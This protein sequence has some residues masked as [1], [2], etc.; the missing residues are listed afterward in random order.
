MYLEDFADPVS[1]FIALAHSTPE[2]PV[3]TWVDE[4][5]QDA[6][7]VSFERL[8]SEAGAIAG[9]LGGR[10]GLV[11]G[12][13]VLIIMQ[14]GLDFV[15][16]YC[17]CLLGRFIP[18]PAHPY[19]GPELGRLQRIAANAGVRAMLTD[20]TLLRAYGGSPAGGS[21]WPAAEWYDAATLVAE[22]APAPEWKA[23]RASDLA[24]L[25][26][27]S[28]STSE[29]KGVRITHG[30]LAHQLECNRLELGLGPHR[31]LVLWV[32]QYHDLGLISGLTSAMVGNG[33]LYQMSPLSFLKR[34]SVWLEVASRVRATH[35]AAPNFAYGLLLRRT[36]PEEI[37]RLSLG[38]VQG[39]M[40]AAEP[41]SP[42]LMKA[43]F[44]AFSAAGLRR[45]A[46]CAAYGLA[47]HTVGV[48]VFGR[49][50]LL[51]D[52]ESFERR[53]VTIASADQGVAIHS[54]GRPSAGV[55]AR[56]V[57][58]D[59]L[60][61]LGEDR[62]GEIWVDSPSK[63]DGYY[64]MPELTAEVFHARTRDE[65]DTHEYL[66]TGDLGFLH[67]GELFVTGRLKDLMIFRGRN[68][69]PSDIELT[70]ETS[71]PAI[72]P[73]CVVA[74]SVP[75][76]SGEEA[77]VVVA[78]VGDPPSAS[79]HD[80]IL[81]A[82]ARA[83]SR[84]HGQ[85]CS[86]VVLVR[87]QTVPKTMSGKLRRRDSRQAFLN[88]EFTRSPALVRMSPTAPAMP[89][90]IPGLD[91][92]DDSLRR[93]FARFVNVLGSRDHSHD[94]PVPAI[95][96]RGTL[97]M[98]DSGDI[99]RHRFF[100]RAASY[101][102]LLRHSNTNRDPDDAV[103]TGRGAAI[104][105][106][107]PD[108]PDDLHRTLLDVITM[109]GRRGLVRDAAS[110]TRWFVG[111]AKAREQLDRTHESIKAYFVDF[112]RSPGS[113]T[114]MHY[115]SQSAFHYVAVDGSR[116]FIRYRIAEATKA[117]DAGR[118]PI[119]PATPYLEGHL[120]R[121]AGDDRPAD[122]LRQDFAR[123]LAGGPVRYRLA[124]QLR[125]EPEGE[126]SRDDL[127]DATVEWDSPWIDVADL[128]LDTVVTPEDA[129][130]LAFSVGNAPRD[131]A[132]VLARNAH[133]PAS[134]AHLRA[135][136][137][138]L[139]GRLRRREPL[140]PAWAELIWK[141]PASK[142]DGRK[143]RVCVLGGGPSGLT[144]ART[145]ESLGHAVT[146]FER[147]AEV[148]GMAS[149]IMLDGQP[150]DLGAHLCTGSYET[151]ADLARDLGVET[152][153]T[154]GYF[155]YELKSRTVIAQDHSIFLRD[156]YE[157]YQTSRQSF[158]QIDRP[159]LAHSAAALNA[160]VSEW[161]EAHGLGA[162]A[163]SMGPN[164]TAA[165]YGYLDDPDLSAVYL[166]KFSEMI[167]ALSPRRRLSESW[168]FTIRNGFQTLWKAVQA[169]LRDVRCA[170][171]VDSVQRNDGKVIV[172][173]G[174]E[175]WTFDDL[176]V[177]IPPRDA[178]A[179]LDVDPEERELLES[180]RTFDYVTTVVRAAD[181]PQLGLYLLKENCDSLHRTGHSVAYH[182]R[183]VGS[184][185]F[186][187]YAYGDGK[188]DEDLDRALA[189]DIAAMGGTLKSIV[190]RRR[191]SYMPHPCAAD[192]R[193]GFFA[194]ME[195]RQGTRNTYYTGSL[196]GFELVEC[197]ASHART[198]VRSHF[199]GGTQS[200]AEKASTTPAVDG[201]TTIA[202]VENWLAHEL[203]AELD[204]KEPIPRDADLAS[205]GIDS[206]TAAA[207]LGNL[208]QW[209]GWAVPPYMIFD[210]PTIASIAQ[211]VA[212]A[213][214]AAEKTA[215]PSST[216][217]I[218]LNAPDTS[219]PAFLVGGL[220]GAALYLRELAESFPTHQPVFALQAAG[221]DGKEPPFATVAAAADAYLS[222]IRN[223]RPRGP[224]R[225]AGHS[226][227]GLVAYEMACRL[228]E[229]GEAVR[230]VL[231]DTMLFDEGDP[232]ELPDEDLAVAEL[233]IAIRIQQRPDI[234]PDSA[235]ISQLPPAVMREEVLSAIAGSRPFAG[236]VTLNRWLPTYRAHSAAMHDFRPQPVP[237]LRWRLLKAEAGYP[238]ALMHPKRVR[239]DCYA[240]PLLGWEG[241]CAPSAITTVPGNH[242]TMI[243]GRN[244]LPTARAMLQ[245]FDD[246]DGLS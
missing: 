56:I 71:H 210:Q 134:I 68:V 243:L 61:A 46:F 13:R 242:Y 185:V 230:L 154:T 160:P 113:F 21:E 178:L 133:D 54:C 208:T 33:H 92:F 213:G 23:P 184:D 175:E 102:V 80:D 67:E 226:F 95:T 196:L 75:D 26:Y 212:G 4:N 195:G 108:K 123:R 112:W 202:S 7:T 96:A 88:G 241:P 211:L 8:S 148:G 43:F 79:E 181:L 246:Q 218:A 62:V 87:P 166:L 2:A 146:L 143:R 157:Q 90:A 188:S 104:R 126:N 153:P 244:A 45:E 219:P 57:D 101:P 17:G 121:V 120:A 227:G 91:T 29:P 158:P 74:F 128:T 100:S 55:H 69:Y 51:L 73:R 197:A 66:R 233:L 86:A 111:D 63:A 99:P 34:P 193:A 138:D 236:E 170:A 156:A 25:Q 114:E 141:E 65:S 130:P 49:R 240:K 16:A 172:K 192:I 199:G 118:V 145:L 200:A 106:L 177:A 58:P 169:D 209:L 217:L 231:L 40:S 31:S 207:I 78:E 216:R 179:V 144:A 93:L 35:L 223:V 9:V 165:G 85:P 235:A 171:S 225:L 201:R 168:T 176:V 82:I 22:G 84:R 220:M 48:S 140:P 187:F 28:G 142:G 47:E 18:V 206:V 198:I 127:L 116:Y 30:N 139:S 161:L 238:P 109:T 136:V 245:H 24:F 15:R 27:T 125:P 1:R 131:L 205:Y 97:R 103:V 215:P 135:V 5:G 105:I 59:S 42:R 191:F 89:L 119:G 137:Y 53:V 214:P 19:I 162:L 159:G 147:A 167:G 32:P 11:E 122:Y 39:V 155:L 52:A 38:S 186:L 174:S 117:V 164:Y 222:A 173:L 37:A 107:D 237:G 6:E 50:A 20:A 115:H 152:E 83:V 36:S 76:Q 180:T 151:V 60:V 150:Y 224:Y 228:R 189:E 14:P 3:C 239:Y 234:L 124:I 132:V 44:D 10:G 64:A 183:H 190:L 81:T 149:S 194:R 12:D 94:G 41:I 163:S 203:A 72:L 77:L 110:Y 204:I 232:C 182:H 129:S 221:L 98:L 70:A 229:R